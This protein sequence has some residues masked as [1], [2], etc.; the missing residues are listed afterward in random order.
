LNAA[1]QTNSSSCLHLSQNQAQKSSKPVLRSQ[2][3][4]QKKDNSEPQG[5]RVI[6][7][8]KQI[9]MMNKVYEE[10]SAQ[11]CDKL[12]IKLHCEQKLGLGYRLQFKCLSCQFVSS[13]I[14]AFN[15]C[16]GSQAAAI[17]M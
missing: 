3:S 2:K 8:D 15:K 12:N 13:K 6:N 4:L 1:E 11:K 10:H 9:A 14:E 17:I 7:L 5:N 16:P